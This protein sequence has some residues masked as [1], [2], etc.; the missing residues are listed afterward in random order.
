VPLVRIDLPASET[1][2]YAKSVADVVY[3][4]MVEVLDVPE[5][6]NFQVITQHTPD[7]LIVDPHYLGIERG[8]HALII[9]ITLNE[10]RD[11]DLKKAFFRAL[12]DALHDKV[13]IR[14]EDVVIG[15]TDVKKENWSFGNGE[16]QYAS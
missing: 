12:A 3:I 2:D 5:H 7:T 14:Q 11:I 8:P 15:L 4:T 13:G 6:D 16:A 9:D 10:G 1:A